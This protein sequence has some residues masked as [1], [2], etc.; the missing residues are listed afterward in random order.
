MRCRDGKRM[1]LS[2]SSLLLIALAIRQDLRDKRGGEHLPPGPDDA[3]YGFDGLSR[4][5]AGRGGA[6]DHGRDGIVERNLA[7]EAAIDIGTAG[8]R[9]GN[10]HG[11]MP[12]HTR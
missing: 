4:R 10:R 2:L 1:I 8:A 3:L 7:I 5:P 12:N 11:P 9:W 6:L